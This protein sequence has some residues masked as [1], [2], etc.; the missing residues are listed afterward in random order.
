[1]SFCDFQNNFSIFPVITLID[2]ELRFFLRIESEKCR[3]RRKYVWSRLYHSYIQKECSVLI[4]YLKILH[5]FFSKY[6]EK[7]LLCALFFS[8]WKFLCQS[9]NKIFI[10]TGFCQ[11]VGL[12][13]VVPRS[14]SLAL[15]F[16]PKLYDVTILAGVSFQL[17]DSLTG[18]DGFSSLPLVFYSTA[19]F[20]FINYSSIARSW[21]HSIVLR[22][23]DSFSISWCK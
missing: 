2:E 7:I 6:E 15:V 11:S 16:W 22:F 19:Y 8:R 13:D 3:C 1:M 10:C 12:V 5:N 17:V 9:Y 14:G 4:V 21:E 23:M 20:Y 18:F